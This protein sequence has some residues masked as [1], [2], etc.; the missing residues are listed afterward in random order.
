MRGAIPSWRSHMLHLYQ[1]LK[2]LPSFRE[3]G[4]SLSCSEQPHAW[5]LFA[6]NSVRF[7]ITFR[8]CAPCFVAV[9]VT[10]EGH[11][12]RSSLL[13]GFVHFSIAVWY[14]QTHIF[15][16]TLCRVVV[17]LELFKSRPSVAHLFSVIL[18]YVWSYCMFRPSSRHQGTQIWVAHFVLSNLVLG[19]KWPDAR[20][21][22]RWKNFISNE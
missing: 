19:C 6:T 1:Q 21:T 7:L 22:E 17:N 2:E 12:F 8:C 5:T 15:P 11:R 10:D 16:E 3:V 14:C 20:R 13:R 4:S 9:A 18:C